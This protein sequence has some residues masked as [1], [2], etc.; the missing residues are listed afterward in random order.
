MSIETVP[1]NAATPGF[2]EL[3]ELGKRIEVLRIQRGLS[4]QE[5]ARGAGASRQ[6]LWRVATGKSDLTPALRQRLADVLQV[7]AG[8]LRDSPATSRDRWPAA[9][10]SMLHTAEPAVRWAP[11]P[12]PQHPAASLAEFLADPSAVAAALAALPSGTDG[13][14]LKRALLDAIE[15]AAIERALPLGAALFELR[16]RVVN[17]EL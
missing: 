17:G 2:P 4:K 14:R 6:Q 16:R 1:P 13:I 15:D 12:R 11:S 9:S 3:T 8:E 7:E 10:T 5:L